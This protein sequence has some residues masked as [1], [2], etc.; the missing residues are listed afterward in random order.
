M[1][2]KERGGKVIDKTLTVGS[3]TVKGRNP[4]GVM[5]P[6]LVGPIPLAA[7]DTAGGIFS[8][9]NPEST[10]ILVLRLVFD[11]PTP[12]TGALTIDAG[13]TAVSATTLSDNLIDGIDGHTAGGQFDNL[14]AANAGTNG[15]TVQKLAAGGWVTGS[16]AS[17]ASAGLVGNAYLEYVPV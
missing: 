15:K 12:A 2:E 8:W 13:T 5:P 4:A 1:A 11:I 16:T 17:G 3:L 9:Q 14:L 6:K 7:V 10:A